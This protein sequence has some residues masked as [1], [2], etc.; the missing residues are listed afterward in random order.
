MQP[1]NIKSLGK[2]KPIV[3][4]TTMMI[5][6]GNNMDNKAKARHMKIW[7]INYVSGLRIYKEKHCTEETHF[8]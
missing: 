3:G 1:Q 7:K 4:R 5:N 8:V 6:D 2:R